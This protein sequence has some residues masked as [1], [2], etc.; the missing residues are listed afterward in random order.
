MRSLMFGSDGEDGK[1]QLLPKNYRRKMYSF[2]M[3]LIV[4]VLG[5]LESKVLYLNLSA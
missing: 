1:A 2:A 4:H 5:I 3:N